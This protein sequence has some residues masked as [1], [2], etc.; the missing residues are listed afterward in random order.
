MATKINIIEN[1]LDSVLNELEFLK[2]ENANL[3]RELDLTTRELVQ[4]PVL[5]NSKVSQHGARPM[6]VTHS[7][8]E[9]LDLTPIAIPYG[10]EIPPTLEQRIARVLNI[11][12]MKKGLALGIEDMDA[13]PDFDEDGNPLDIYEDFDEN[14]P[15]FAG[16]EKY[17]IQEAIPE[18][19]AV[20]TNEAAPSEAKSIAASGVTESKPVD[21]TNEE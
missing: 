18:V 13:D 14:A 10:M 3:K 17:E 19:P 7:V 21:P 1:R 4:K 11:N 12:E 8:G 6:S 16:G 9:K 5:Q 15:D 2:Q 20:Q